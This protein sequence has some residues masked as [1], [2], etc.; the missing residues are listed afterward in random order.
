MRSLRAAQAKKGADR[1]GPFFCYQIN[2]G[3]APG[4]PRCG[5][6]RPLARNEIDRGSQGQQ[7]QQ[8]FQHSRRAISAFAIN[9]HRRHIE[10]IPA[11]TGYVRQKDI[12]TLPRTTGSRPKPV[13]RSRRTA[14]IPTTA[15]R[16]LGPDVSDGII[17]AASLHRYW[18]S[19]QNYL[20]RATGKTGGGGRNRTGVHR[21][22]VR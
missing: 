8:M 3:L 11:I 19:P 13:S 20:G 4:S 16:N 10:I 22:A 7:M 1:I 2:I 18:C 14:D 9:R 5:Y 6:D 17:R 12:L 15:M 21:F